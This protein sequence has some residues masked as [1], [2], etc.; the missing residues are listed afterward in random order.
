MLNSLSIELINT[1][2]L[3]ILRQSDQQTVNQQQLAVRE[4]KSVTNLL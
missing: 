2:L 3:M 1:V 4:H